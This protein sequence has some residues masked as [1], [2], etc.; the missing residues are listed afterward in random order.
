MNLQPRQ[1]RGKRRSA[2]LGT[3][4]TSESRRY[5]NTSDRSWWRPPARR[6][7]QIRS[8]GRTENMMGSQRSDK[9]SWDIASSVGATAVMVAAG[10]AAETRRPDALIYDPYAELLVAAA[11]TGVWEHMV[12]DTVLDALANRDPELA[13][14][15]E[16][17]RTYQA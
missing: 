14:V 10:R 8:K 3:F 12:D 15:I 11:G 16:H 7:E 5:R 13:A 9:D 2:L 6:L 4:A 17:L 1:D